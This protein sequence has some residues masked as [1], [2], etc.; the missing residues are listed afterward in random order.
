M[1]CNRIGILGG[2]FNPVH[3]GHLSMAEVAAEK[4]RLDKVLFVP[5]KVSPFKIG[6]DAVVSDA[7]RLEM[8]K[9]SIAG[10]RRFEISEIELSRGGVSYSVDTVKA[11]QDIYP[12]S[13]LFFIIG[14][15][16]L[17]NLSQWHKIQTLLTL[18]DFVIIKRPNVDERLFIEGDIPH[19]CVERLQ[20]NRVTGSLMEI[21]STDIRRKVAEGGSIARLV[22]PA[23]ENY[24]ETHRLYRHNSGES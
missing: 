19:D 20:Q 23:V 15:D 16:S 18:C 5:C 10:N 24:I 22:S 21:S 3:L 14:S 2:S 17:M 6:D 4:F 9:V 11:L 7:D 12:S 1:K 13:K 8:L